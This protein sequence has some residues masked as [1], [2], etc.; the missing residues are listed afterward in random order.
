MDSGVKGVSQKLNLSAAHS[1]P[2]LMYMSCD[3]Y[4]IKSANWHFKFGSLVI[5]IIKV[6]IKELKWENIY[7]RNDRKT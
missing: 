4:I 7:Y 5:N 3:T 1:L 2:N 6:L